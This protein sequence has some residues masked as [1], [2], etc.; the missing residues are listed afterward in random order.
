MKNDYIKKIIILLI[1]L[2]ITLLIFLLVT[3]SG[4]SHASIDNN[5]IYA[6][7]NTVVVSS[8]EDNQSLP[9]NV[10]E[11]LPG[12][13][14]YKEYLVDVC[15]E[16]SIPLSFSIDNYHEYDKH[17]VE[18]DFDDS[19]ILDVCFIKVKANNILIYDDT[20]RNI[21][22]NVAVYNLNSDKAKKERVDYYISVYVPTWVH[23]NYSYTDDIEYQ[24]DSF[25]FDFKWWVDGEYDTGK[26]HLI[27][28]TGISGLYRRIVSFDYL[29]LFIILL[30]IILF[31]YI[32][33]KLGRNDGKQRS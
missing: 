4:F 28:D 25:K 24:G 8:D 7:D 6:E 12:D 30:F 15:Y 31:I 9:F 21:L 11:Y 29:W 22:D 10:S 1:T 20:L 33:R 5:I 23:D 14:Y 27:P 13:T 3:V 2:I 18:R 32:K 26:G 19:Y 17:N 16:G